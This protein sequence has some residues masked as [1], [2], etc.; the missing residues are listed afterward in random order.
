MSRQSD[1]EVQAQFTSFYLQNVTKELAEDL[2]KVRNA[3]DFKADSVSFLVHA[4]QQGTTQF[5]PADQRR[6]VAGMQ[7]E[8]KAAGKS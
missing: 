2:D 7:G 1:A 6:V 8:E 4:L 3:D 5:S